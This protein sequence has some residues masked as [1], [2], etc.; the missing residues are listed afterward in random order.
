MGS[1]SSA[2]KD[3]RR[4]SPRAAQPV[5]FLTRQEEADLIGAWRE[6]GDVRA[7][8]RIVTAHFPLARSITLRATRISGDRD[9]AFQEGVLGLIAAAERFDPAM[10]WRFSTYAM[11][12]VRARVQDYLLKTRGI[13][14]CPASPEFKTLF[15]G[16][17]RTLERVERE[18]HARGEDI[19]TTEIRA[20]AAEILSIPL[21][22]I[23]GFLL[24]SAPPATG[25]AMR[26]SGGAEES[27]V[28]ILDLIP[29]EAADQVAALEADQRNYRIRSMISEALGLL[30]PRE[31]DIL[32]RRMLTEDEGETLGDLGREY[33]VTGERIRQ[34]ELDAIRRVRSHVQRSLR[35]K[36]DILEAM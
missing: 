18:A 6:H 21:E 14:S 20:R 1:G 29:D 12:W 25:P 3:L 4:P 15:Y 30:H 2:A 23:E 26:G 35:R 31:R 13:L 22:K 17:S 11:W 24:A 7:R 32:T 9:E 27:T 5:E 28:D 10:G 8:N 34:I 33:G 36:L 19:S 16:L